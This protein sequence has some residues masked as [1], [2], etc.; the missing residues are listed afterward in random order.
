MDTLAPAATAVSAPHTLN[1]RQY[2]ARITTGPNVAP[3]PPHASETS[4]NIES[5]EIMEIIAAT[6]PTNTRSSLPIHTRISAPIERV[7]R[8]SSGVS[9]DAIADAS[10]SWESAV[11][12]TAAITAVSSSPATTGWKKVSA[13]TMYSRSA[14]GRST[15]RPS[16]AGADTSPISSASANTRNIHTMAMRRLLDTRL[17]R[18]NA[19]NRADIRWEPNAPSPQPTAD[20]KNMTPSASLSASVN[21]FQNPGAVDS[22]P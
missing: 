17:S 4:A 22:S 7:N 5:G 2:S 11:L 13:T 20:R 14:S 8:L 3:I 21:G 9:S 1:R 6:R 16:S 15:P 19:M 10:S 18:S 12:I